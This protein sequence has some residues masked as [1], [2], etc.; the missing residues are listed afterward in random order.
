MTSMGL[1]DR[2]LATALSYATV[3]SLRRDDLLLILEEFPREK[4]H[5]RKMSVRFCFRR[6]VLAYAYTVAKERAASQ[7]LGTIS[8]R[9]KQRMAFSNLVVNLAASI[10]GGATSY[11]IDFYS[12]E[13]DER[14]K[15]TMA[16]GGAS[17]LPSMDLVAL[18]AVLARVVNKCMREASAAPTDEAVARRLAD[19]VIA[20]L[21]G[22][23]DAATA[24]MVAKS[25]AAVERKLNALLGIRGQSTTLPRSASPPNFH[26]GLRAIQMEELDL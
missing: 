2:R 12:G 5:I 10:D 23:L 8:P 15:A 14:A 16:E 6:A 1:K 3:L 21:S 20:Q 11:S 17:A 19:Q 4:K 25:E 18:E 22:R 24:D 7:N 9:K 13:E 26:A